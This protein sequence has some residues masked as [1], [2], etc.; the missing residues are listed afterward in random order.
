MV[1]AEWHCLIFCLFAHTISARRQR[2]LHFPNAFF[3]DF[4]QG[5][6]VGLPLLKSPA[7]FTVPASRKKRRKRHAV[8]ELSDAATVLRSVWFSDRLLLAL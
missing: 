3:I 2:K 7:I 5:G 6:F 8:F 1:Q 4:S